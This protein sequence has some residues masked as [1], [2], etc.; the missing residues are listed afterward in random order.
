MIPLGFLSKKPT[1][2]KNVALLTEGATANVDQPV[3]YG[4]ISNV[5]KGNRSYVNADLSNAVGFIDN[6]NVADIV[7]QFLEKKN[8]QAVLTFAN[9]DSIGNGPEPTPTSVG[10]YGYFTLIELFIYD[11]TTSSWL[12][13]GTKDN[14]V[15][16]F[17]LLQYDGFSYDT[18][19]IKVR[20]WGAESNILTL[21]NIE[22]Y[23]FNRA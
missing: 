18:T 10:T 4:T 9:Q 13:M 21:Y 20:V 16:K 5:L 3:L 17:V 14:S 11:D 12:S 8:I 7:I 1:V 19:K 2:F 6:T 15:N 23:G 22:A